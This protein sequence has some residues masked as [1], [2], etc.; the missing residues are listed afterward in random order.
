[1]TAAVQDNQCP[2]GSRQV[3][4]SIMAAGMSGHG[5]DAGQSGSL[6]RDGNHSR[7]QDLNWQQTS[8]NSRKFQKYHASV[9]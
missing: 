1:M 5:I 8:K 3:T 6:R 7:H 9:E 4:A 2:I